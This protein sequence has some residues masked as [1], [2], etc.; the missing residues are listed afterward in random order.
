MRII[1]GNCHA[2]MQ[3]MIQNGEGYHAIVTDPP[4]ELGFMGRNW[5]ASGI[6][7]DPLTWD[8]AGTLLKSDGY[9]L[10]FSAPRTFHQVAAAIE[11]AGLYIEKF[12]L[13]TFGQAMPKSLD[14]SKA[15]DK[16]AGAERPVLETRH[17]GDNR[18][19]VEDQSGGKA[20]RFNAD[21]T[22]TAPVTPEATFFQGW[23]TALKPGYEIILAC[24]LPGVAMVR[25]LD[26]FIYCPKASSKDR[27]EYM[28]HPGTQFTHGTTRRM[29]ENTN[30]KG[31]NHPTVKPTPL[32]EKLIAQV[33]DPG[34][35]ILDPFAGSG[36]TLKACHNLGLTD[37][38]GIELDPHYVNII[39]QRIAPP[40]TYDF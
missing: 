12:I 11:A 24:R 33:A 21:F 14:V 3:D 31:N 19:L 32:M 28:D 4:Y 38:T 30:T 15:I 16:E 8:L 5:D 27:H 26:R 23:G 22:V 18:P 37:A 35:R 1:Q 10:V 39:Q 6:A 2:V 20:Y 34:D 9:M 36:S 13:W 17:R 29:I 40:G 25:D 7:F